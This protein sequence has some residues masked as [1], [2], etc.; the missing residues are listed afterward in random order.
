MALPSQQSSSCARPDSQDYSETLERYVKGY[1]ASW[2]TRNRTTT[3]RNSSEAEVFFITGTTGTLG[4]QILASLIARPDSQVG[5]IYAFNRK[6]P[7]LS[8]RERH[9][10]I[11]AEKGNGVELLRSPKVVFVE[12]DSSVKGFGIAKGLYEEVSFLDGPVLAFWV[13]TFSW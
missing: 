12:G 13:L 5:R 2:P 4:S 7:K 6:H 11:F 3:T 8:F 1:T 10:A 9:E